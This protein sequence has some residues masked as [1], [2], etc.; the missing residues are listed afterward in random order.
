MHDDATEENATLEMIG[1]RE[2]RQISVLMI[3]NTS[4]SFK[5]MFFSDMILLTSFYTPTKR[6]GMAPISFN[7]AA[8]LRGL[9]KINK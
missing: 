7:L 9:Q 2:K 5:A 3:Y 6:Q 4:S 1:S 8:S